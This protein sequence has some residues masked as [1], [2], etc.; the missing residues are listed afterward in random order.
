[1]ELVFKKFPNRSPEEVIY[2][3][4]NLPFSKITNINIFAQRKPT[5][6]TPIV[7]IDQRE[8]IN[9]LI[10]QDANAIDDY[11][12]PIIQHAAVFK[13]FLDKIKQSKPVELDRTSFKHERSTD[14]DNVITQLT[15]ISV[16][17]KDTIL[18]LESCLI[19]NSK[20]LKS[21][22]ET[23]IKSL[24][25]LLIELQ[26]SKIEQKVSFLDEYEKY[27][28]HELKLLKLYRNHIMIDRI[29]HE[30]EYSTSNNK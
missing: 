23:D 4:L 20:E 28:Y 6:K 10:S 5:N 9:T 12:N 29:K 19:D 22:S 24:V 7:T 30:K 27:M 26:L 16:D 18:E 8:A 21:S 3:F 14:V 13:M 2:Q 1:M 25:K 17:N 15:D 11:N